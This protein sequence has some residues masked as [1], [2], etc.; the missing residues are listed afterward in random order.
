MQETYRNAN[1][2]HA[3]VT[4]TKNAR[5]VGDDAD[6]GVLAGPVA[7]HGADGLALL[8]GD[9]ES[10]RA[11]VEGRVLQADVANGG[12][13]DQG[14]E[15][16]DVVD[17]EAVEEI[18][19]VVLDG[20]Q[21]QVPVD[22]GLTGANHLHGPCALRLEALHDVRKKTGEVLCDALFRGEGEACEFA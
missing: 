16:A 14:H 1:T 10:L 4:E 15:L 13:V 3:E 11:G 12:R 22:V 6:L 21:V 8:D 20:G 5:A 18:D 7:Q 9:V 17:E 2:V 19:V